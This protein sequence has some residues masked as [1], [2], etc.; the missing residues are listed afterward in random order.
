[1]TSGIAAHLRGDRPSATPASLLPF[2]HPFHL[3]SLPSAGITRFHR[4]CGPLRHPDRPD[5]ALTGRRLA[6]ATPPVG[7]PVLRPFPSSMRAAAITPAE[8]SVLASLASRPMPAFPV[9]LAGRLPHCW[10]R[11]LRSVHFALQPAWSLGHPRRP[12]CI[13]VLQTMSLPP[14]SAPTVTGWSDSCR[15]GFAPAEKWRLVTAHNLTQL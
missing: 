11:G 15:A 1:M 8:R 12:F 9:K 2:A 6:R 10:F 13:E 7:L 3:R 5:L 4:Y 14:S